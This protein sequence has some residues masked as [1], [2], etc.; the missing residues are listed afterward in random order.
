MSPQSRRGESFGDRWIYSHRLTSVANFISLYPGTLPNK[1]PL[2]G[3]QTTTEEDVYLFTILNITTDRYNGNWDDGHSGEGEEDVYSPSDDY[4]SISYPENGSKLFSVFAIGLSPNKLPSMPD[5]NLPE[6]WVTDGN[7]FAK[8]VAYECMFQFCV[9]KMSAILINGQ[10]IETVLSHWT[11][12]T[13]HLKPGEP[14]TSGVNYTLKPPD[15]SN[16]FIINA[17]SW[18]RIAEWLADTLIGNVT[19]D[20]RGYDRW[21]DALDR[22]FGS[23]PVTTAILRQ[24]NDSATAFPELMTSLANSVSLNL[25]KV[26]YQPK[27]IGKACSQT[28]KAVVTWGWLAL[29]LFELVA[30]LAFL[31]TVIVQTRRHGLHPWTN[32]IL[33]CFFHGLDVRPTSTMAKQIVIK[34]TAQNML[35]EFEPHHDGGRLAFVRA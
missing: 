21:K 27:V 16:T 3:I 1:F 18:N 12:E 5:A 17:R 13:L 20:N 14:N 22:P 34:R 24:M 6:G 26:S 31:I 25:R 28:N 2:T 15:S 23:S 29:P 30:S 35:V 19:I 4:A 9:R 32:N 8:P 7:D 33:P 10:M 11:D